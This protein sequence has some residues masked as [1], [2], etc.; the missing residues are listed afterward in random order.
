MPQV[1]LA[2]SSTALQQYTIPSDWTD[3]GATVEGIG[4]GGNG[5]N[6]TT[7][8]SGN[9]GGGGAGG[10]YAKKTTPGLTA[11]TVVNYEVGLADAWFNDRNLLVQ[12]DNAMLNAVWTKTNCT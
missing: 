12:T 11:G 1:L 8:T 10:M 7:G 6:G 4:G 5:A 3:S 9:G 2:T